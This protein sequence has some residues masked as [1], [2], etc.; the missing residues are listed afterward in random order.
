MG[1]Q[2][3]RPSR[4][5]YLGEWIAR[6]GHTQV[7]VARAADISTSYL[8]NLIGGRKEDPGALILFD[9]SEFLGITVNDLYRKPPPP[10]ATKAAGELSPAEI[11]AL[12]SLLS[13]MGRR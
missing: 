1:K 11:A 13:K 10:D 3:N 2:P 4:K 8:S 6:L 9:I 12:G 5:L 7:E